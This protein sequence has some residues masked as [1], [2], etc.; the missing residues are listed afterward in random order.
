MFTA[1]TRAYDCNRFNVHSIVLE[2]YGLCGV[3]ECAYLNLHGNSLT[4]GKQPSSFP[5]LFLVLEIL[6][7][8]GYNSLFNW[9][10]APF[11]QSS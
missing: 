4:P 3:I 11:E 2:Q 9:T 7:P 8:N 5:L 6:Y 10:N 1:T